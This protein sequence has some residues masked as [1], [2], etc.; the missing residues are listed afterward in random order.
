MLSAAAELN[1]RFGRT[2]LAD[3]LKGSKTEMQKKYDLHKGKY[4]GKLKKISKPEI[5]FEIDKYIEL[6]YL[7]KSG[8]EYPV[9][10]ITSAGTKLLKKEIKPIVKVLHKNNFYDYVDEEPEIKSTIKKTNSITPKPKINLTHSTLEEYACKIEDLFKNGYDIS[11]VAKKL[12]T[13]NGKIAEVI[14]TAIENGIITDYRHYINDEIYNKVK[15]ILENNKAYF[16][17][18]IQSKMNSPINFALLR[19]VVAFVR[20]ELQEE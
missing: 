20:K 8:S 6:K 19:I 17:H 14:Q 13:N 18:N 1:G 12:E 10:S 11:A 2:T 9:I 3:F 16:L 15:S 7:E 4:F 5:T